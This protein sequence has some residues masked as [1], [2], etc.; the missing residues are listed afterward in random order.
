[1]SLDNLDMS[2][3]A[4]LYPATGKFNYCD[5]A[6]TACGPQPDPPDPDPGDPDPDPPDPDNPEPD[7]PDPEESYCGIS[8]ADKSAVLVSNW[9]YARVDITESWDEFLG[10]DDGDDLWDNDPEQLL[11]DWMDYLSD[12]VLNDTQEPT[13]FVKVSSLPIY[14]QYGAVGWARSKPYYVID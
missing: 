4:L 8:F 7:P 11:V 2:G 9:N 3:W 6:P 1:L 14:A 13:F 12:I 5:G 10:S